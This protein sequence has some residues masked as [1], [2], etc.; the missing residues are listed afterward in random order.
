MPGKKLD[1]RGQRD[2]NDIKYHKGCDE[3]S[4][5]PA[6][7]ESRRPVR[8]DNHGYNRL[9]ASEPDGRKQRRK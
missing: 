1:N 6:I 5:Y 7:S 4:V 2:Y 8:A 3:E 9:V